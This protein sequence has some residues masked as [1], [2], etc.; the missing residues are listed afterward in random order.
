MLRTR[1]KCAP[2]VLN[3]TPKSRGCFLHNFKL[4]FSVLVSRLYNVDGTTLLHC[5][6]VAE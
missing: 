4:D 1:K 6:V 3:R 2:C 5:T